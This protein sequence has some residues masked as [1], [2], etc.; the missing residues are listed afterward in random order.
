M[1]AFSSL[2]YVLMSWVPLQLTKAV[3]GSTDWEYRDYVG[4]AMLT[5]YVAISNLPLTE[6]IYNSRVVFL[7]AIALTAMAFAVER[8][9]GLFER[10]Y[11]AGITYPLCF[12][13]IRTCTDRGICYWLH[14]CLH[15]PRLCDIN[16][17]S[18][19]IT[20]CC[21]CHISSMCIITCELYVLS[22]WLQ[23]EMEGSV[24]LYGL[25]VWITG[26]LGEYIYSNHG[27]YML[28]YD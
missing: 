11:S 7:N 14:F 4:S 23:I 18:Y 22:P 12:C 21:L 16:G 9:E 25:I 13:L 26:I 19:C 2:S 15:T 24:F 3:Y 17:T 1:W 8:N 5:A 27:H 20:H 28:L 10:A 6:G